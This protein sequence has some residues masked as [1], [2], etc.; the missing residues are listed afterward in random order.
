[1]MWAWE[2]RGSTPT[3]EQAA[4][5]LKGPGISSHGQRQGQV[6]DQEGVIRE[7][8]NESQSPAQSGWI[9]RGSKSSIELNEGSLLAN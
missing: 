6:V 5:D 7:W 4:A 1:M 9:D 2:G 8:V 3:Y